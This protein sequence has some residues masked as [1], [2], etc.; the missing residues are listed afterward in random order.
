VQRAASLLV[1]LSDNVFGRTA[2]RLE[3]LTDDELFWEPAPYSWSVRRRVDG[4]L[5]ADWA[6]YIGA[7][8]VTD[9]G[10]SRTTRTGGAADRPPPL[11]NLAWRLWHLTNVYGRRQNE[12]VLRGSTDARHDFD[13]PSGSAADALRALAEAHGRWRTVLASLADDDLDEPVA[14]ARREPVLRK[15]GYVTAMLDEFSHHGAELGLLRDLYAQV[16]Q[17]EPRFG[18]PPDL[19]KVA[20]AGMWH[21]VPGLIEGGADVNAASDGATAL[22]LACAAGEREIVELLLDR[23]ADPDAR[24]GVAVVW[25]GPGRPGDRELPLDW[26][27]HF[28]RDEIVE[29]LRRRAADA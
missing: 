14:T 24:H 20:W 9:A 25:G 4:S 13:E 2:R 6:P 22:H 26:A 17:P 27:E 23:G 11:T 5:R 1:E 29:L 19:A 12:L 15:V 3:G 8:E 7:G 18:D 28:A 21:L 16:H 10:T